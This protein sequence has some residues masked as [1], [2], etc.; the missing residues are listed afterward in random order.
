[1]NK[2]IEEIYENVK[3]RGKKN[4]DIGKNTQEDYMTDPGCPNI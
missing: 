4:D 1:M 3:Q 2:Q